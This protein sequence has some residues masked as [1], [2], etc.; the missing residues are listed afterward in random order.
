[1]KTITSVRTLAL[2]ATVAVALSSCA[3]NPADSTPSAVVTDVPEDTEAVADAAPLEGSTRFEFH[4]DSTISFVGSKVTGSHD[5]GFK[6]FTGGFTVVD[7]ALGGA[8]NRI[9]ID[10]ESTW[11]DDDRL[12][13]HLK[14][15]DFFDVPNHPAATFEALQVNDLGDGKM[16]VS[17]NFTLRGTTKRITFPAEVEVSE[18]KVHLKAE[19]DINRMDFGVSFAGMADD[20]I[21]EEV[22]I[23]LDIIATPVQG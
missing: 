14:N 4:E 5:G 15:D 16:E 6:S 19:F 17:G 13:E 10:M 9:V 11:S 1:M 22:V 20:L 3:E 2:S 12:T 18:D 7:G 23:R 21:R 8:D